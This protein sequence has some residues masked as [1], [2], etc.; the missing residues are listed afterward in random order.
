[1]HIVE[2]NEYAHWGTHRVSLNLFSLVFVILCLSN[3][4]VKEYLQRN[5]YV[6]FCS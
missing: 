4:A 1:M 6:S 5:K 2:A 3:K